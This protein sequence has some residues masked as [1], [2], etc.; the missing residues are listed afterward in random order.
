MTDADELRRLIGKAFHFSDLVLRADSDFSL[1]RDTI[2][3]CYSWKQAGG[4]MTI[5]MDNLG[6]KKR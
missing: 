4:C 6:R 2:E 5:N 3:S 1:G